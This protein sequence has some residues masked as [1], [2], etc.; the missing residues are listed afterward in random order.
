MPLLR[1]FSALLLLSLTLAAQPLARLGR[2]GNHFSFRYPAT[3]EFDADATGG[4]LLPPAFGLN[5]NASG[6]DDGDD[7]EGM[8]VGLFYVPDLRDEGDPAEVLPRA[9]GLLTQFPG[10]TYGRPERTT[11]GELGGWIHTMR[12]PEDDEDGERG[13]VRVYVMGLRRGGAAL[14]SVTGA[15][16]AMRSTRRTVDAIVNSISSQNDTPA[17][18]VTSSRGPAT[19][20]PPAA[21]AASP[22]PARPLSA[23][24]I[25][26]LTPEQEATLTGEWKSMLA[27]HTWTAGRKVWKLA[28]D[29][30]YEF[31]S[32]VLIAG[33]D[34]SSARRTTDRGQ[35]R[36]AIRDRQ[37]WLELHSDSGEPTFLACARSGGAI[38]IDG[39]QASR[40]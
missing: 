8:V 5:P 12:L 16:Q 33:L 20:P 19:A 2:I 27:G 13:H 25:P 4:S 10:R 34:E 21:P 6:N 35:W 28:P 22:T 14:I 17:G 37:P 18:P 26:R 40:P 9:V 7:D 29:G 3:W 32:V 1:L 31:E 36:I 39:E 23:P 11:L 38:L 30:R 24:P 15:D